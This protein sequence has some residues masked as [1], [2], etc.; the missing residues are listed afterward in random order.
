MSRYYFIMILFAC[1]LY[2]NAQETNIQIS[3]KGVE[4]KQV[5]L[6]YYY[7]K[8]ILV[9][10]TIALDAK[11]ASSYQP[12]SKLPEG[13]YVLY[14]PNQTYLDF[15]LGSDQQFSLSTSVDDMLNQTTIS[16]CKESELFLNY[17]KFIAVKQSDYERL[18]KEVE[19]KTDDAALTA[20]VKQQYE[21]LNEQVKQYTV[22]L[23]SENPNTFLTLF[24][25]GLADVDVPDLKNE[26]PLLND[27]LLQQKRYYYYRNHF[28]DHFN[29]TDDRLLR[30]P[31]F[32]S[33]IDRYFNDVVPQIP[34]TVAVEAIALIEQCRANGEMFKYVTSYLYNMVNESK[35]MGMDAALVQIA[36]RY[37]LSGLATWADH[38]FVE[39]LRV[40]VSKIKPTLI[41]NIAPD[42]KMGAYNQ[43]FYR[44]HELS[45]P[46]VILVFWET[47]CGHCKKEI[48]QLHQIWRDKLSHDIKVFCVY[49]QANEGDWKQFIE[50]HQLD[51]WINV[52]D[53]R[54]VTNFRNLYNVTSTPQ[55]F[56]LDKDKK[57]VAKK[58]AVSQIEEI[59]HYLTNQKN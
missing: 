34:D 21:K 6:G 55:I 3:V 30:T 38:K 58:I 37:Y 52:Y 22:H 18:Q 48:P 53:P 8:Q 47:E 20:S 4:N 49:T 28:F 5:I 43:Q 7:N 26:Y 42:L 40:Q 1:F 39:E 12:S 14:F 36:E 10:D 25:E 41:G 11:G 44:L 17:Q 54:N 35:I 50:T 31:Y 29:F 9:K 56:I 24:L 2:G 23:K 33:R 59:M 16:G 15:L 32:T 27:S 51:E 45:A 13:I 57:I 46:F 19:K